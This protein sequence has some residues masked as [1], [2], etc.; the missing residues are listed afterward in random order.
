MCNRFC[1]KKLGEGWQMKN[2]G[3]GVGSPP[4]RKFENCKLMCN[5]LRMLRVGRYAPGINH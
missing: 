1:K 4:P 3:G 2:G 5:R